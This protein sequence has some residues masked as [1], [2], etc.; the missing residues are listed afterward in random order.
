MTLDI[1]SALRNLIIHIHHFVARFA[2]VLALDKMRRPTSRR[3]SCHG[4]G[5]LS[6]WEDSQWKVTQPPSVRYQWL[7]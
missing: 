3:F 2:L 7:Q 5:T 4:Q 6:Q 1:I